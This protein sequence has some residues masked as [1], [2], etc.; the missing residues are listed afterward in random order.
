MP[1]L[2]RITAC[3][4]KSIQ[5]LE[6]FELGSLNVLIGAN[7]T[8]KSN[9][10]NLFRMLANLSQK[11]LQFFIK[12]EGGPDALLFGGRRRTSRLETEMFFEN[13]HYQYQF[14]LEPA[15]DS[16]VFAKEKLLHDLA[17]ETN[18]VPPD[19][20]TL[21]GTEWLGGHEESLAV[22]SDRSGFASYVLPDMKRWRVF[23]FQDMSY[24]AQVR[25]PSDV[26]DN[27]RLK[28]DAGNLA[29]FLRHLRERYPEHYSR[30]VK[31]IRLAAPFFGDFAYRK[32][33]GDRIDL[34]WFEAGGDPDRPFGP[35]QFSD[36]TLRF[37]CLATLLNQ[38]A[39]LQPDLILIDEPELGLHPFAL[40]LLA[41]MLKQ[42]ADSRQIIV[43][44]QSAELVSQFAPED[45]VV[46]NRRD[47]ES[48]FERLDS[49][50]LSEWLE[51][52]ALG[53]LWRMN[54]LGGR[55]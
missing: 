9:L 2:E 53:D 12:D 22:D 13:G 1:R 39:S 33:P 15:A 4:F 11:R 38:P 40:T 21:G 3:G 28:P 43:S 31:A 25:L 35:R 42:S 19:T 27:L 24:I 10:L 36:G 8:G 41:E 48:I 45:V 20:P 7:G 23:H 32:N 34:E 16:M 29:P 5:S 14:S 30:I 50:R 49:S 18:N 51:D 46:V 55:P 44:T 26:R 6:D 47:G 52:Y 37:I 17:A 54:I